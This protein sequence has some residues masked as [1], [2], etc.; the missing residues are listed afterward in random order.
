M[1][2]P[3]TQALTRLGPQSTRRKTPKQSDQDDKKTNIDQLLKPKYLSL[4]HISTAR[5]CSL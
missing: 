1:L 5:H 4:K 3:I 2:K